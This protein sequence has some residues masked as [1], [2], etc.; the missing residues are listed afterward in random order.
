MSGAREITVQESPKISLPTRETVAEL[1]CRTVEPLIV[2]QE[3]GLLRLVPARS[4]RPGVSPEQLQQLGREV[5]AFHRAVQ[6]NWTALPLRDERS[7]QEVDDRIDAVA[8]GLQ[9]AIAS[10]TPLSSG[11]R[12]AVE[13]WAVVHALERI[14]DWAVELGRATPLTVDS[15]PRGMLL[16]AARFL[17]VQTL[18]H[19]EQ[20]LRAR[21]ARDANELLDVGEALR[22]S[23]RALSDSLLPAVGQGH[24]R[25]AG[26]VALGAVLTAVYGTIGCTQEILQVALDRSVRWGDLPP[27]S[28]DSVAV[29]TV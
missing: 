2:A 13:T 3:G 16:Q 4:S 1:E 10:S 8:W 25:P 24:L 18:D 6:A 9:R 29:A 22:S 28:G 20:A 7:W 14:A 26:A 21:D 17:H 15:P 11:G 5:V 19:L 23:C 27:T 12:A